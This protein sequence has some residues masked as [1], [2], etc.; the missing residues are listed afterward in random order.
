MHA[1]SRIQGPVLPGQKPLH[2]QR[3]PYSRKLPRVNPEVVGVVAAAAAAALVCEPLVSSHYGAGYEWQP[4]VTLG[5]TF[6]IVGLEW[7]VGALIRLVPTP[8]VRA[9][10][11]GVMF[12]PLV[13]TPLWLA[14]LLLWP[15]GTANA[16]NP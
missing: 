6:A 16:V 8:R 5:G 10:G 14:L 3:R 15:A 11:R 1:Q 4:I 12:G 9:F 7:S 13:A 2:K